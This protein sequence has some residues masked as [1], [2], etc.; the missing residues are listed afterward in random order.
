[1]ADVEEVQKL[2][3]DLRKLVRR[4][5]YKKALNICTQLRKK[6]PEADEPVRCHCVC[7]LYQ[8]QFQKAFDVAEKALPTRDAASFLLL[9]R[10]YCLYKLQ[11]LP[12]ALAL[13]AAADE[14]ATDSTALRHLQ[15]QVLYRQAHFGDATEIYNSVLAHEDDPTETLSNLAAACVQGGRSAEALEAAPEDFVS[16][17]TK[18]ELA[19]N[20]SI[21]AADLGD[22]ALAE[23]RL[24]QAEDTARAVLAEDGWEAAEIESEVAVIVVQ[25]AY[26]VQLS[27][28]GARAAKIYKSVLKTAG[29]DAD[30]SVVAVAS[31]N[32][33]ALRGERDVFHNVKLVAKAAA[34][35]AKLSEKGKEAVALN[36]AL[37]NLYGNKFDE[38]RKG[39]AALE[40]RFPEGDS[41]SRG[42]LHAALL[43]REGKHAEAEAALTALTGNE[44][45]Q[46]T[47]AHVQLTRGE[48]AAAAATL[49]GVSSLQ[50]SPGTVATLVALYSAAG[51][52]DTARAVFDAA[53]KSS[54]ASSSGGTEGAAQMRS[55]A[56]KFMLDR[57]LLE[58]AAE[59]YEAIAA[60]AEG[61]QRES[62][63]IAEL[64]LAL[65]RV[66]GEA[67]LAKAEAWA[68]KLPAPE[69]G[70][71]DVE[72]SAEAL[73]SAAPLRALSRRLQAKGSAVVKLGD[74]AGLSAKAS[75]KLPNPARV[76]KKRAKARAKH[77]A[78]LE[79]KLAAMPK[80]TAQKLPAPDKELWVPRRERASYLKKR[81][82]GARTSSTSAQGGAALDRDVAKLDARARKEAEL[83]SPAK[84]VVKG[85]LNTS[86]DAMSRKSGRKKKK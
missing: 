47:L 15:A 72:L 16:G 41:A 42:V 69:A 33:A 8:E 45:A 34:A 14:T 35:D 37:L 78:K 38:C 31:N 28:D 56:A 55:A 85:V 40:Q 82:G 61:T 51:D 65:T 6:L 10:A 20:L 27:G 3:K 63:A 80:G 30:P 48:V 4:E 5:N 19:Y 29:P 22:L 74:G 32:L 66:G 75:K 53:V 36:T 7:L 67:A 57:G 13:I 59:A 83:A 62:E 73:E 54:S 43:L 49:R 81:R 71:E 21:A 24:R 9:E 1:M 44:N 26:V 52:D 79:A 17:A 86:R 77:I 64:V 50:H 84:A 70:P 60:A 12:E 68:A 23:A 76:A 46:L 39:V 58:E 11:R 25:L 18:H 2:Y